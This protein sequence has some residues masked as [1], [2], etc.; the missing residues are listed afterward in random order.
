MKAV[1]KVSEGYDNMVYEDIPEPEATGDLVKIKIAYSG[2]C[3]TDLHA[4]KGTYPST[5]PP[6]VLGHE[7]SGI[8]TAVG[9]DVRKVKIGDR[10]TSETTFATCGH[11][12]CCLSKDYN[13]CSHRS[14]IGT[15]IN[16]SM[17][18]YVVSREESI[19]I[20]PD[21]VSLLSAALTEPLACGVHASIEKGDVQ[22]GNIVCIFGVGAIGQMVA[23][24]CK[25]KG[26]TVIVAGL[27][28][29]KERFEI[30]LANGADRAV[31]QTQEDLSAVVSELTGG[32]GVDIAFECSGAVPATNKAL[33]IT[34]RKGKVVQMGVFPQPKESIWTDLIL[35]KEINYV[36]SRSQKPS[37]WRESIKLLA[38]HTVVPEK[39]VTRIVPLKDWREG[40][41]LSIRGEGVK[42]VIACNPDL[43]EPQQ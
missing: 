39:I 25:A 33:E 11:C 41:E 5:K 14:G 1:M 23:Q 42:A 19:H 13:L 2:V 30:A 37:S 10:V 29:D 31:D 36:G 4:F 38:A 26:A 34:R 43:D 6:V 17:A 18:E 35:H 7:F 22:E 9:P 3:G 40:F 21:N 32:E 28:S 24:V 15:Q 16:G 12:S 8:V 27:S 20:I